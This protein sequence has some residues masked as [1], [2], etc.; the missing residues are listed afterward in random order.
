MF[1]FPSA[2][3][4]VPGWEATHQHILNQS[5]CGWH[6][7]SLKWCKKKQPAI[8][9]VVPSCLSHQRKASLPWPCSAAARSNSNFRI[10]SHFSLRDSYLL[11]VGSISP[12]TSPFSNATSVLLHNMQ[13]CTVTLTGAILPIMLGPL[14]LKRKNLF[15]KLIYSV[16]AVVK[17]FVFFNKIH[18]QVLKLSALRDGAG[19]DEGR[20]RR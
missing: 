11:Q 8:L 2:S 15:L 14:D 20:D 6:F 18:T 16:P 12:Q 3:A 9:H 10:H 7:S 17:I 19:K 4:F 5:S 1:N 13:V